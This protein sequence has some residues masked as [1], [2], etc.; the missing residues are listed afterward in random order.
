MSRLERHVRWT[1]AADPRTPILVGGGQFT[2]RTAREN[3]IRESLSPIEM[4]AK[5]ARLALDD[6]GSGD[7]LSREVD[8]IAVVRFT[9]DSPGD[10]GRL[11]KR[12]FRNPPAALAKHLGIVPRRALYTATGGNTPQWLVNRTAEDI[13]NGECEVAL[14][15]GAEYIATLLGCDEAGRRSRLGAKRRCGS[16]SDPEEI[17]DAAPRHQR[18]RARVRPAFS[19]E[20]LSAVRERHSRPEGPHAAG[21][22]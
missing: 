5:A 18:L 7:T 12:M 11:P 6:C 22:S 15:V 10:Q 2:Q 9:A 14:L 19:G 13:A 17:G 16:G 4:L 8:T 1:C 3:K 21:A 20:R